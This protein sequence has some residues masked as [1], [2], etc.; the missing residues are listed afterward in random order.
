M[1]STFYEGHSLPKSITHSNLVLISKKE[2]VTRFSK[3]R[4]ISLNNFLNKVIS[5]I[6]HDRMDALHPSLISKNQS[7]FVK[8]RNIIE[9][10]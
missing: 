2:K 10:I 1:A 7:D 3:M 6:I 4:P 9:N 8:E 5:R